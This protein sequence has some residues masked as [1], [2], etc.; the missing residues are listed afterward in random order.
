MRARCS[1]RR[2]VHVSHGFGDHFSG[3][4]TGNIALTLEVFAVDTLNDAGISQFYDGFVSPAVRR[5][6]DEGIGCK[7][8]AAPTAIRTAKVVVIFFFIMYTFFLGFQA[9]NDRSHR[10]SSFA[11]IEC[12]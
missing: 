3:F 1:D 5:Y 2:F 4:I 6:V 10:T 8:L 9:K 11:A 12:S 7:A